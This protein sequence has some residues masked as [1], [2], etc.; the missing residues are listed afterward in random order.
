MLTLAAVAAHKGI[1]PE[2]I[3][4]EIQRLTNTEGP[5]WDTSFAVRLDLGHGLT[6][7]ERAIM[8]G[9]ARHCEVHKLLTGP[10]RFDYCWADET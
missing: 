6:R 1:A 10:L 5:G 7:R 3:N 8:I 2:K 9:S 4:V